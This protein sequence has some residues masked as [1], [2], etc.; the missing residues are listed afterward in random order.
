MRTSPEAKEYHKIKNRLF[1]INLLFSLLIL[2]TLILSGFFSS[3]KSGLSGFSFN[4]LLLNGL[5]I[6]ILSLIFYVLGF[7][8]EF[9]EG[10][11][12][13]HRFKL[14]NQGLS[15]YL[16]DNLKNHCSL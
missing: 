9:Y 14:S 12:L 2:A 3:L 1:V 10:F 5:C 7:P 4:I 13:E 8:L 6:I 15:S 11:V 16:K